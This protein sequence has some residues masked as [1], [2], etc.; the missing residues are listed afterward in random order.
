MK[1]TSLIS[2]SLLFGAASGLSKAGRSAKS[3]A[4]KREL[5][6][7]RRLNQDFMAA[8]HT[9]PNIDKARRKGRS[10]WEK[11]RRDRLYEKLVKAS[12][13]VEELDDE[14]RKLAGYD[15]NNGQYQGG[16]ANYNYNGQ[17]GQNYYQWNYQ[18]QFNYEMNMDFDMAARSFKYAGCAAIKTYDEEL[19]S[20]DADPMTIDT[21]AV[22]RLCPSEH[23]NKYS[24]VGCG[25]NYGE[26]VVEM[27]TYL[28]FMLEYYEERYEDYCEYCLPCDWT[29]Q[30]EA[31]NYLQMCYENLNEQEWQENQMAQQ[32]AWEDYYAA[33]GG[34]MAGYNQGG[35]Y[36][37]GNGFNAYNQYYN[38]G[39]NGNNNQGNMY[40]NQNNRNGNNWNAGG[41]NY[42]NNA[43]NA[44][45]QGNANQM[46]DP[47][48]VNNAQNY[49]NAYNQQA[50]NNAQNQN[51]N[52]GGNRKLDDYNY[53][54]NYD[55][56]GGNNNNNNNN[57]A[58][59]NAANQNNYNQNYNQNAANQN[60]YN[61][62]ANGNNQYYNEG[63]QGQQQD[64]Q[65][66]GQGFWGSDGVWYEC[67]PNMM[68]QN[69]VECQDGT[70]CD[71]CE[72]ENEQLFGHCD[73]Y[74]CQDYYTY[75]TNEYYGE[76]HQFDIF[77]FL[78]CAEFQN[79]A[80][81]QYFIGPHCGDNHFTISLGVFSDENCANY[82]GETVTLSQILGYRHE[83]YEDDDDL[84]KLPRECIS[85]DG[86]VSFPPHR[87]LIDFAVDT[88]LLT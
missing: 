75:C 13:P 78:E 34:D 12:K 69:M 19:A 21:Y 76:V 87:M 53:N 72:A 54:Y 57:A 24:M 80:G 7:K 40:N 10:Q 62:N 52:N 37:N 42:N 33:N 11:E 44:Y 2:L 17:A 4:M 35:Q 31:K 58:N 65:M 66:Q 68:Y 49:N 5:K 56:N 79:D 39:W 50:N 73:D 6:E 85:C 38:G 26:Y 88:L 82:V 63:D 9:N 18:Q 32:Q 41:Y 61:G 59:Q 27:K 8:M 43:N 29:Q 86:T 28:G 1:F 84:F 14:A 47:N 45:N 51:Y 16:Q 46:C 74:I 20:E 83:A 3:D 22:F 36:N 30:T 71:V 60:N 67:D 23:C 77:D 15:Y 70:W 25:K 81:Q 64:G 48:Q 55:Y